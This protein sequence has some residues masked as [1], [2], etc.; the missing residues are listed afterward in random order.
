MSKSTEFSEKRK[1]PRTLFETFGELEFSGKK[2]ECYLVNLSR[3][4]SMIFIDS[5]LNSNDKIK[6]SFSAGKR[7]F[8]KTA[9]VKDSKEISDS[10]KN[11]LKIGKKLN[12][13]YS[14]NV[15]FD[16]LIESNEFE[17]ININH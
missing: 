12:F 8:S 16:E 14:I 17:Y 10:R 15:A 6:L 5:L 11:I 2:E 4:G 13:H 7:N 3:G 1:L 9:I